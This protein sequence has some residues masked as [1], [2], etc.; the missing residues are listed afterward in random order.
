M[1]DRLAEF[2]AK[3][4]L[5]GCFL[6]GNFV[7]SPRARPAQAPIGPAANFGLLLF[8]ADIMFTRPQRVLQDKTSTNGEGENAARPRQRA[9]ERR[10]NQKDHTNHQ[11][12]V[13]GDRILAEGGKAFAESHVRH[14]G[15][16][17]R[18][19][20]GEGQDLSNTRS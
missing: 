10:D 7:A 1:E 11:Q 9:Q 19:R 4:I 2:A 16:E 8:E 6:L 17:A 14:V 12:A 18:V 15:G 13:A 20:K 5:V 3:S